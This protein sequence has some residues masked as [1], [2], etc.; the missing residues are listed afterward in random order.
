MM[1]SYGG[2]WMIFLIPIGLIILAIIGW[3]IWRGVN[4]GGGCCGG[5]SGHDHSSSTGTENAMETLRR[6]YANGE[7]TREQFEQIKRDIS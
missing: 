2:I 4:W 7:I 3:A 5:H 6:R 1:G